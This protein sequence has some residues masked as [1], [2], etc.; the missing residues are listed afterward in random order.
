M[1]RVLHV[2]AELRPSGAEVALQSVA[3]DWEPRG[4]ECD[5]LSTGTERG[6]FAHNLEASGYRIIHIP[7]S[8]DITFL[9]Q[10]ERLVRAEGYDVVHIQME[11]GF[12][13]TVALARLAGARVV[14]TI[15]NNFLFDGGLRLRRGFQ[16]QMVQALGARQVAISDSVAQTEW[17][18]FRNRTTVIDN[19]IRVDR[20]TI[21]D[22]EQRESARHQ[23]AV[24]RGAFAIATVGNCSETK[25]HS[26]LLRALAKL[27]STEWVWIH[28]GS[29]DHGVAEESL[30]RDLGVE[31]SCRFLGRTDPLTA[32]HAA[33]LYVMPSLREGLGMATVEALATGLPALLTSVP[34]NNDLATVS[35]SIIW[36][37]P[38]LAS[39]SSAVS[40]AI[41]AASAKDRITAARTQR[42]AVLARFAPDKGVA[43][44]AELYQ[45]LAAPRRRSQE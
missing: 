42:D 15:R 33:D 19:W 1:I 34:G 12:V 18:R 28:V 26:T 29:D 37:A 44:Y 38:D 32:L 16:R 9:R 24:P 45:S 5:I 30:A 6:K 39:I 4:I 22:P 36:A 35:D 43:R 27:Q 2:L 23:L 31:R 14:R 21:P 8:R 20:F 7:F 40:N 17:S 11:R 41:E 25:N 10:Y 13:Y 3:A